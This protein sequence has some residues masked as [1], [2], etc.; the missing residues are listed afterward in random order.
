MVN[1]FAAI[2]VAAIIALA[3]LA[4]T[5]QTLQLAQAAP[6][7]TE[8]P[9]AARTGTHRAMTGSRSHQRARASAHHMHK[10]RT[11]PAATAPKT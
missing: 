6:A 4:A 7:A 11:A 3:P 1:K 2:G 9:P 8:A 10:V 5:A